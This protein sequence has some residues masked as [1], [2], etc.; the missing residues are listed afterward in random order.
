MLI[1]I[2]L[3]PNVFYLKTVAELAVDTQ[4]PSLSTKILFFDCIYESVNKAPSR[5][6]ITAATQVRIESATNLLET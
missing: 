4:T 5:A 1:R 6:D 3:Q 2:I